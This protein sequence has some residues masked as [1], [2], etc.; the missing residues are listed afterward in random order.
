MSNGLYAVLHA[1]DFAIPQPLAVANLLVQIVHPLITQ[2][3]LVPPLPRGVS[4]AV[5]CMF[6]PP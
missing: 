4:T 6:R 5:A 2:P 1:G 3:I